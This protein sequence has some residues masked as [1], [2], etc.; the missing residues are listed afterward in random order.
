M[1][2]NQNQSR[3]RI[4]LLYMSFG[5]QQ[6]KENQ[7]NRDWLPSLLSRDIQMLLYILFKFTRKY[8]VC[9]MFVQRVWFAESLNDYCF[10]YTAFDMSLMNFIK[11]CQIKE[12]W[13]P[14]NQPSDLSWNFKY[15]NFG[16]I[17]YYLVK[18]KTKILSLKIW[19]FSFILIHFN[20]D[21]FV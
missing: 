18:N 19:T 4:Y 20:T 11:I 8:I 7:S 10:L 5:N 3:Y 16:H 17:N 2:T 9:Y 15:N 1:R 6:E 12:S 21:L 13:W 14:I